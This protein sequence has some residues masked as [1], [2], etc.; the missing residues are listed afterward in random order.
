MAARLRVLLAGETA[1]VGPSQTAKS[2][3]GGPKKGM[4]AAGRRLVVQFNKALANDLDTPRAIRILRAATRQ[5][6]ADTA[7]WML[8]ILAGTASLTCPPTTTTRAP[9][10]AS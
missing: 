7:R 1:G 3:G 4:S 6:E 5:G 10:R 8:G 9:L 2:G